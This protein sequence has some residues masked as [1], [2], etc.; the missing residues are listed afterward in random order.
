[1]EFASFFAGPDDINQSKNGLYQWSVTL[2]ARMW[3]PIEVGS[4]TLF[5][6]PIVIWG[7]LTGCLIVLL[8]ALLLLFLFCW[9][10]PRRRQKLINSTQ[11]PSV[12]HDLNGATASNLNL[13]G[14]LGIL[15][16]NFLAN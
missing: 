1:M 5:G 15:I 7:I 13:T 12:L 3:P 16:L 4:P 10:L 14:K 8:I 2:T 6:L 9:F 11:E